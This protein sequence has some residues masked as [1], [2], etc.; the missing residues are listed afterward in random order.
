M[1]PNIKKLNGARIA[2]LGLGIENF[3]FIN[4]LLSKKIKTQ[5]T[6]FDRNRA[7]ELGI[8]YKQ[9]KNKVNWCLGKKHGGLEKFDII[10][11]SPGYPFSSPA[12]VKARRAAAEITSPM[13]MF[14]NL[15]P[16]TN[17]IGVTG[18]KGK[19]TTAALIYE[20]IK[21]GEKRV[22]LG[23]N[24]GIA[25][26]SFLNKIKKSDWVV[27]ELSSFQLEDFTVSPHVAVFTNFFKEHLAAA[28]P[29]NPN[30]HPSLRHYW[31]SKLNIIKWQR[32]G[33]W[34]VINK[35]L[36]KKNIKAGR[37]RKIY[38]GKSDLV[39]RLPGEHNKENIAAATAV[40]KIIK[41]KEKNILK[42]ME[43]R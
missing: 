28:D 39:S 20:I 18:T 41:I 16:S 8:R 34:A 40:A 17:I 19:G 24:I 35:T 22:W 27:L 14:F 4:F 10:M 32:P 1:N 23:G 37:G 36:E 42:N 33:D 29:N 38:F 11:R 7:Q 5:F 15:S 31:Q 2:I 6:V 9:L 25:P 43:N 26:F 30:Y 21:Q 3:A 12:L 13:R